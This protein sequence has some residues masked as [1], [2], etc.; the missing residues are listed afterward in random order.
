[1]YVLF[2][3]VV[4]FAFYFLYLAK[5]LPL[6][7]NVNIFHMVRKTPTFQFCVKYFGIFSWWLVFRVTEIDSSTTPLNN[8]KKLGIGRVRND[9]PHQSA[10]WNVSK[11]FSTFRFHSLFN[12]SAS[13][14]SHLVVWD[15]LSNRCKR[16]ILFVTIN[17]NP[18]YFTKR[19]KYL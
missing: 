6:I 1:M 13:N 19:F 4:F 18:I 16:S 3:S 8:K 15:A 7:I 14:S 2:E 12:Y 11:I 5:I 10:A 9:H 17:I